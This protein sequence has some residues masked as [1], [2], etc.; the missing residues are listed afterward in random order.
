VTLEDP[1]ID[2]ETRFEATH[3]RNVFVAFTASVRI[4]SIKSHTENTRE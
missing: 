1:E 4:R 3:C 2:A